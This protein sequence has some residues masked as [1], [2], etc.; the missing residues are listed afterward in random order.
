MI[1]HPNNSGLAMDQLT[2]LYVPAHFVRKVNVSYG[3]RQILSAEV[4]FTISENPN[5]RFYF[6]PRGE[7]ELKAEIVDSN[8]LKF[9]SSLK[10]KPGTLAGS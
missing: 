3:G 5:F 7:G 2:R 8:N 6:V 4:D 1:S 10:I 9:E